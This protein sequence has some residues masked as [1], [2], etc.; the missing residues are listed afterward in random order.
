MNIDL[1]YSLC[2]KHVNEWA[3]KLKKFRTVKSYAAKVLDFEVKRGYLQTN[4]FMHVETAI[5][6]KA[7]VKDDEE[8]E[9]F[10]TKEQLI[11]FLSCLGKKAIIKRMHYSDY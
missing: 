4:P 11:E 1:I 2:Q 7:I 10:Y 6:K 5:K 8:A 9:N 3:G